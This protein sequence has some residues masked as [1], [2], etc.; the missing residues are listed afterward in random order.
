VATNRL[1]TVLQ[2]IRWL[3]TAPAAHDRTDEELL[4]TF[5]AQRDQTSFASLVQR[6]GG[7][8]WGV[9][10]HVLGQEQDAEDA[11]QATFL[12]LA[13]NAGSVRKAERLASW[14]HGV[15]FRIAK[16]AKRAAA[17]RRIHE[18]R[19][20]EMV[21]R[22]SNTSHNMKHEADTSDLAF[23]ELQVVLDEEVQ[24]LP[25]KLRVPFILCCL[26]GLNKPEAAQQ[27]GWKEGTVSSRLD[28][29][30][31]RLRERLTRRGVELS[32]AVCAT[33]VARSAIALPTTLAEATTEAAAVFAAGQES[34]IAAHIVTLAN[35]ASRA[36]FLRK[37][38]IVGAVFLSVGLATAS[39]GVCWNA[40]NKPANAPPEEPAGE[41]Q[42]RLDAVGDLL[43]A[44]ALARFGDLRFRHT[45]PVRAFAFSPDGKFVACCDEIND[46][47]RRGTIRIW[48]VATG[49][50]CRRFRHAGHADQLLFTPDAKALV[51]SSHEGVIRL[52]DATTGQQLCLIAEGFKNPDT[53]DDD[54][55]SRFDEIIFSPKDVRK[56]KR[57]WKNLVLSADGALLAGI[58]IDRLCVW[59]IHTCKEKWKWAPEEV[60][61][62]HLHFTAGS[63]ELAVLS[64][65][66]DTLCILDASSG[67]E[68]RRQEFR[69]PLEGSWM[70]A[71]SPDGKIFASRSG[72]LLQVWDVETC[73]ELWRMRDNVIGAFGIGLG[74]SADTK[75]LVAQG[76][77]LESSKHA[78]AK[79]LQHNLC[80]FDVATGK[81]LG[82][83]ANLIPW[84][85]DID[86]S[87]YG[88]LLAI[89]NITDEQTVRFFSTTTGKPV[90]LPTGHGA[91]VRFLAMLAGGGE[92]FS[93]DRSSVACV[94]DLA[95]GKVLRRTML[96]N[97]GVWSWYK[98]ASDDTA[99]A[100]GQSP[101]FSEKPEPKTIIDVATGKIC[102][103]LEDE[104]A[105]L[106][107]SG[108]TYVAIDHQNKFAWLGETAT[109]KRVRNLEP[110][111]KSDIYPSQFSRDGRILAG[112]N[113]NGAFAIW[114]TATGALYPWCK[115]NG[116][117]PDLP[118][119][120][121][122]ATQTM[123]FSHDS[124]T[125][126]LVDGNT[127]RLCDVATGKERRRLTCQKGDDFLPT[128]SQD[129]SL[130]VSSGQV[131][132]IT[133]T[134]PDNTV[135]VWDV[136]TGK[137]VHQFR[138]H[139][140]FVTCC[141]FSPDGR[142]LY[143]GSADTTILC[144]GLK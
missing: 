50:E 129:G 19:A 53:N 9:C 1:G 79:D 90:N 112:R 58:V 46:G 13:R 107:P 89:S 72:E 26:E 104:C 110:T 66:D 11:F 98:M 36:L 78:E 54:D 126:V 76:Y 21:G 28:T 84:I 69:K 83:R 65:S 101:P 80:F 18:E 133:D 77:T 35:G 87:P 23:R 42:P 34:S 55:A 39:V 140:G 143:T 48:E 128:M 30:R 44:G 118:L 100:V 5:A 3:V 91:R 85:P 120:Y 8:V 132:L 105:V 70:S 135:H 37:A 38:M 138:G 137:V 95:S 10:R 4:R 15:A 92:L 32:A 68:L 71:F 49:K 139:T 142:R 94:W 17:R 117:A 61:F 25:D 59:D 12:V 2:H 116:V 86:F 74:F 144:W 62:R 6:H 93:V 130:A 121:I 108:K 7:L 81:Q 106:G 14:L 75:V 63:K 97:Q 20:G 52:L 102:G 127:L 73:R 60:K 45:T 113:D 122:G 111:F 27:L 57:I 96:P 82:L 99:I 109:G 131:D 31:K 22:I 64:G 136:A 134:E 43:P 40:V 88:S 103:H 67:R 115:E 56:V 24:R 124:K 47:L 123:S 125:L 51:L 114:D 141:A 41:V 16:K 33:E 29:A 119:H